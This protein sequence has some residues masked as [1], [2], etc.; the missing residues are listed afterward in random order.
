L[1]AIAIPVACLL[2]VVQSSFFE[3]VFHR[4]WLHRPWLPKDCFTTHT[5]IHH[6]LCKFEDTFHV[7]EEEQE[8]ALH[9]QWWGGPILIAINLVPWA[10]LSWGLAARGVQFPYVAFLASFAATNVAYYVGYES[11]HYFMHK[12]RVDFIERSKWFQFLKRHHRIHHVHM[13]RNLNVLLPL[14]DLLLGT[15]VTKMPE[16]AAT[17]PSAR[18]LARRHSRFGKNAR[19]R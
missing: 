3:W 1:L 4:Y 11:L 15:L 5:L 6:Q 13:N 8:E 7:V 16:A 10:L 12:P 2:S 19:E 14:A 9:F 17:P 18:V